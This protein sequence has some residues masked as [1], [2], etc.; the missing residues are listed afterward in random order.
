MDFKL[1]IKKINDTLS[2]EEESIFTAWYNESDANRE[3]FE[4]VQ[5]NYQSD[6]EPEDINLNSAWNT[7]DKIISPET[8]RRSYYK[9]AIAASVALLIG[10]GY[11]TTQT[12]TS[13]KNVNTKTENAVVEKEKQKEKNSDE[14]ILTLS[15]GSKV[16][17]NNQKN[18]VV[19]SQEDIVITKDKDGQIRYEDNNAAHKGKV[20]FN[21]LVTPNGKTFQIALPDG[22]VVWMNAGSSLKYPTYFEGNERSVVLTGEAYFEVT[23][24]E[25]MP[26]KVLS[27]GQEVEVLGTHFNIRAYENEPVLKTTLLEG[28]IK[29][30]EGSNSALV[31]PGQQIVVS[32]DKHSMR[33]KEVNTELAVA[34]KNRLFYFENARY[35][36]IMREIERWY[37]VEVIY[38]GKIPDE[39][40][41]GAI[42]KDLKLNQVLKMLESKD[43]HF[44]ISG[45]E[46]I[47]TQ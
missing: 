14:I 28:K 5:S 38:K 2:P 26:F 25:K 7:I 3:Y 27:N 1:I 11:Y 40:F 17:L 33:T 46:V 20:S 10:I 4:R 45:K 47:V 30:T 32:V 43:I 16:V 34:W 37:D 15:D 6:L 31:K 22:T 39:R 44:K 9:Y 35:D 21:T 12:N 36:E 8:N 18:G 19:A 42:Q 29:I 24:N 41:E 23:R 13:V